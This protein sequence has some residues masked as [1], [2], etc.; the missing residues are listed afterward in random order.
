MSF[1]YLI[2]SLSLKLSGFGI[3]NV[4]TRGRWGLLLTLLRALLPQLIPRQCCRCCSAAPTQL[5]TP[6]NAPSDSVTLSV[7]VV[8]NSR[9]I[10][11]CERMCDS[12]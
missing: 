12:G 5:S 2:I 7:Q 11:A 3:T 10:E 8:S 4:M 9:R 1:Y 6:D